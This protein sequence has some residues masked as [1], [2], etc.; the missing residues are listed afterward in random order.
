MAELQ[1]TAARAAAAA[2]AAAVAV[3]QRVL[4]VLQ[5]QLLR[6]A[7]Y[8]QME[9]AAPS[10]TPVAC[11]LTDAEISSLASSAQGAELRCSAAGEWRMEGGPAALLSPPP[12]GLQLHSISIQSNSTQQPLQVRVLHAHVFN[13]AA[14]GTAAELDSALQWVLDSCTSSSSHSN[15]SGLSNAAVAHSTYPILGLAV[16][17][18]PLDG[19]AR[20]L[21]LS[22]PTRCILAR[23]PSQACMRRFHSQRAEDAFGADAPSHLSP[24][25]DALASALFTPLLHSVLGFGKVIKAA[26][27]VDEKA[28]GQWQE[29]RVAHK[30]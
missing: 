23:L 4:R 11:S 20:T 28:W 14:Q 8:E 6:G 16:H 3:P 27:R 25:P 5:V 1:R 22:T 21:V 18:D 24:A 2:A 10:P 29:Q 30:I 7:L 9:A 15:N 19:S 12:A 13:A 26:E 17:I